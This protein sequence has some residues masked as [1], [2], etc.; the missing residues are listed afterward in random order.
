MKT[1]FCSRDWNGNPQN[2]V[3]GTKN[4]LNTTGIY[5]AYNI[6]KGTGY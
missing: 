5:F 6:R 4:A 1:V 3:W 2:G